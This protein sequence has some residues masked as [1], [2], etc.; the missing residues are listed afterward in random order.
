MQTQQKLTFIVN[1]ANN[2][3]IALQTKLGHYAVSSFAN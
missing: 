3:Y 2:W 1:N